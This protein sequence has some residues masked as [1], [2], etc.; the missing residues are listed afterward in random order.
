MAAEEE[1]FM[2]EVQDFNNNY[3]IMVN[4]KDL[5]RERAKTETQSLQEE[6]VVLGR[7]IE[8]LRA[9]N[10]HL[11]TLQRQKNMFQ[12]KLSDFQE[13]LRGLDKEIIA[14]TGVTKRLVAE[15]LAIREKPQSDR[16]CL[17]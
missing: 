6:A 13:T 9:E 15:K 12:R 1:K 11:N 16:E 2:N 4:R 5:L 14:V 3:G 17:R 10:I 7:E 8:T